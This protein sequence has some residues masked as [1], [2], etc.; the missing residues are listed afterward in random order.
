MNE[1]TLFVLDALIIDNVL[2]DFRVKML[3]IFVSEA[4]VLSVT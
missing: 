2:C 3:F 1:T 4:K